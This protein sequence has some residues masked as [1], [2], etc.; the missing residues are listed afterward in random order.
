MICSTRKRAWYPSVNDV[1]NYN[2]TV[3]DLYRETK[4]EK[5]EVLSTKKIEEALKKTKRKKGCVEDKAGMLMKELNKGHAFGSANRRTAYFTA[6][7]MIWHNKNYALAI[8]RDK[9]NIFA[10]KVRYG[11]VNDEEIAR[12]LGK[13]NP[14]MIPSK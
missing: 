1:K 9:Q 4:A 13:D 2:K 8:K 3:I 10:K 14:F 5:H 11:E 7:E 12:F 6:N